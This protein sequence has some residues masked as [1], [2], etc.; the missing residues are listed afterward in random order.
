MY[1]SQAPLQKGAIDVLQEAEFIRTSIEVL[2][3][4]IEKSIHKKVQQTGF[5]LPQMKVIEAVVAQPGISIKDLAR[6]LRMSQSTV[7]GIVERLITKGILAKQP[8]R[9]DK[10]FIQID[11]TENVTRFMESMRTEYVNEAVVAALSHLH[12][13]QR[14]VIVQALRLLLSAVE[15]ASK[16]AQ[17]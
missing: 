13:D 17:E 9:R 4:T 7:S 16:A 5:T 12:A 14:A 6:T 8:G 2:N 3:H 1:S 15:E 11:P 10:R